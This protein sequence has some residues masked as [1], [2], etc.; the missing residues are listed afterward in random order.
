[1]VGLIHSGV[2]AIII[3]SAV[4][5]AAQL[6]VIQFTTLFRVLFYNSNSLKEVSLSDSFII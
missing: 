2:M 3:I 5:T 4:Q 1:M 6:K